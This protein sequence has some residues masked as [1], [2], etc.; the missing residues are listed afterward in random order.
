MKTP[1]ISFI[2]VVC[3]LI[4]AGCTRNHTITL[5]SLQTGEVV[6]F[7]HNAEGGWG[8][9]INGS[10]TPAIVQTKPVKL[11]I[12]ESEEVI[13]N[14]SAG[15]KTIR[16][17]G[18]EIAARAEIVY[19]KNVV[20]RIQDRW[21]LNGSVLSVQRKVEVNGNAPGGFN[22][23]VV[24]SFG[25]SAICKKLVPFPIHAE[26]SGIKRNPMIGK[27]MILIIYIFK[28]WLF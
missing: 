6:S 21:S 7:I 4:S 16:K 3:L 10:S 13:T 23:S 17:S 15:Y 19:G 28:F 24:F 26:N 12:Y 18:S 1:G 20:F 5:G 27:L 8:I 11:E 9:S 2:L 22:S 25:M 14:F